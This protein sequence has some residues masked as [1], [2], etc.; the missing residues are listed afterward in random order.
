[1][2]EGVLDG[3]GELEGIDIAQTVL[4]VG[5]NNELSQTKNFSTQVEG[6]SEA[7]FLSF[8]SRQSPRRSI[9]ANRSRSEPR[10]GHT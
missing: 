8:L 5:V 1:M 9:L 6:V 4:N 10:D 7:G 2:T 3:I